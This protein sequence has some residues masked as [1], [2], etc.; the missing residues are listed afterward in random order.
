M[1]GRG[2]GYLDLEP[3][4]AADGVT[5]TAPKADAGRAAGLI[6]LADDAF[7]GREQTQKRVSHGVEALLCLLVTYGACSGYA[8]CQAHHSYGLVCG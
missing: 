2:Y 5:G 3:D 7:G 1:L 8:S 4:A 6:T